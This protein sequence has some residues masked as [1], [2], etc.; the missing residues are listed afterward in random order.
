MA[1]SRCWPHV[2]LRVNP[3]CLRG[4]LPHLFPWSGQRQVTQPSPSLSGDLFPDSPSSRLSW[5]LQG[6]PQFLSIR[7]SCRP[8]QSHH[9]P[10]EVAGERRLQGLQQVL[11]AVPKAQERHEGWPQLSGEVWEFLAGFYLRPEAPP[12]LNQGAGPGLLLLYPKSSRDFSPQLTAPGGPRGSHLL[13]ALLESSRDELPLLSAP[14]GQH[15]HNG[16]AVHT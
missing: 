4:P 9:D 13:G 2:L 7:V 1:E 14:I 15:V 5:Y 8:Q 11:Q 12:P 6:S 10:L 16:G 3:G